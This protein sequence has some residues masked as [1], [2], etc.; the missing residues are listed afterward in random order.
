MHSAADPAPTT[1]TPQPDPGLPGC[2][3]ALV[4]CAVRRVLAGLAEDRGRLAAG[5][6]FAELAD[7]P[8]WLPPAYAK[9]YTPRLLGEFARCVERVGS[10]L[11]REQPE[12]SSTAEQLAAH[13][14]LGEAL[15]YSDRAPGELAACGIGSRSEALGALELIAER[16]CGDGEMLILFDPEL[17]AIM[18]GPLFARLRVADLAVAAWFEPSR[19]AAEPPTH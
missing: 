12:L 10:E 4:R 16:V 19:P 6:R 5:V 11:D 7:L 8:C 3:R 18:S 14:I 17:R 13:A 9:H 2:G 15:R 1:P